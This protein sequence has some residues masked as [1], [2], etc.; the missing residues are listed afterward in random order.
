MHHNMS[1]YSLLSFKTFAPSPETSNCLQQ[2]DGKTEKTERLMML[3][4]IVAETATVRGSV[5]KAASLMMV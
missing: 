5:Y 2:Q 4:A 1:L 3:E